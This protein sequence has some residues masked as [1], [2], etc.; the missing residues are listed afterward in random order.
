MKTYLLF[1]LVSLFILVGCQS[2]SKESSKSDVKN[3]AQESDQVFKQIV[4]EYSDEILPKDATSEFALRLS[5]FLDMNDNEINKIIRKSYPNMYISGNET[6]LY[7]DDHSS[8]YTPGKVRFISRVKVSGRPSV[9]FRAIKKSLIGD[10]VKL[11]KD[12][13]FGRFGIGKA[14]EGTYIYR[15]N[16]YSIMI[17]YNNYHNI[18]SL[19]LHRYESSKSSVSSYSEKNVALSQSIETKIREFSKQEYPNDYKMQQYVYKKQ[20]AAYRYMLTVTDKEVKK[21]AVREYPNDYAMQKYVYD[22]QLSAKRYSNIMEDEEVKQIALRKYPNDHSMQKYVYDKQL[23]AK[24]YMKSVEDSEVKRIATRE[25]PNDY[26]M[27][28]YTYDKQLSAKQYMHRVSNSNAK[29]RAQREYPNDY[30]MQKYIYDKI[31][32]R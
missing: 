5:K 8:F 24:R 21:I 18:W 15:K 30:S 20:M 11:L 26:S 28:K 32:S 3:N 1:T 31:I 17:Q 9:G 27:Q 7:D 10:I 12:E 22:K 6:I 13:N 19:I 14:P 4:H 16:G 2:S 29:S 23:S 25:Y